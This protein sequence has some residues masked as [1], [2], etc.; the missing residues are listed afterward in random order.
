MLLNELKQKLTEAENNYDTIIRSLSDT[1][2]TR[3]S[4]LKRL[5]AAR[6]HYKPAEVAEIEREIS[7]HEEANQPL[8]TLS[9]LW[10]D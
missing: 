9:K 2:Q 6:S 5:D 8:K 3:L 4:I 7:A 10:L 1:D